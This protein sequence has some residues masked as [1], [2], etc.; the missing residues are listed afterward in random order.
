[1]NEVP[2]YTL[3]SARECGSIMRLSPPPSIP[4]GAEDA[5]AGRG[6]AWPRR[7]Q[8]PGWG[9]QELARLRAAVAEDH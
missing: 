1:M 6:G 8:M 2:L 5:E 4:T 3:A 7:G 9:G